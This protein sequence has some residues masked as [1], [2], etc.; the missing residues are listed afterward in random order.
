[1]AVQ[2]NPTAYKAL[3]VVFLVSFIASLFVYFAV[4]RLLAEPGQAFYNPSWVP[5]LG[6]GLGLICVVTVPFAWRW[7]YRRRDAA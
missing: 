7:L 4:P 6:L 1:M 3:S 5:M 2:D